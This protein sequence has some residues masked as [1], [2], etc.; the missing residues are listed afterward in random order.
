VAVLTLPWLAKSLLLTGNP[1]YPLLY[2]VFG[3][4][5]W[6]EALGRA[7]RAWQRA[8]GMGRSPI[9]FLLL[10]PRVLFQGGEG[11]TRFDGRLHPLAGIL[12]PVALLA[13][14][15]SALV[16]RALAV[17][18]VWFV[19]WAA[20]SQQMRFLIPVL[21]LLAVATAVGGHALAARWLP[22]PTL[23]AWGLAALLVPLVIQANAIYLEQ[24]PRLYAALWSR[25]D[26]L[27]AHATDE[28]FAVLDQRL[29]ENARLLFVNINRGFFS[30]RDFVAD[31]FFEA[32]QIAAMLHQAPDLAAMRRQ[33]GE[34]GITHLLIERQERGPT[35][36][37][38][39]LELVGDAGNRTVYRSPDGRFTVIALAS[40]GEGGAREIGD[41]LL[42]GRVEPE[43]TI[44]Q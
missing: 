5:E 37:P 20:T 42:D 17:T 30:R 15:R 9:D 6:S 13:A 43:R 25:G 1:V 32:S 28:V 27:R 2:D 33:L 21:P 39:F 31:S 24:A 18:A 41:D 14:P 12:L 10:P 36:P 4:P 3:G 26:E 19:L 11:Y 38:E 40:G 29:P 16:R 34:L 8:I 22:R 7:H 35:Y 44:E 23:P